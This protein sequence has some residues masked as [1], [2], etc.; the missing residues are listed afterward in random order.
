MKA[1]LPNVQAPPL[2]GAGKFLA[3]WVRFFGALVSDPSPVEPIAL[4]ASPFSAKA[5]ADGHY[6]VTGGSGVGIVIGRGTTAL[7]T[8][9]SSGFVPMSKGDA[10]LISFTIA[11]TVTFIP[12]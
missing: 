12:A 11:P 6:L 3:P 4:A 8:A 2:D 5:P 7:G 10:I 1:P 9:L